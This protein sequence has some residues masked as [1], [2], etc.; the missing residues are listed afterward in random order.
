M[1][2]TI[3]N[4]LRPSA[5]RAR[6]E[7]ARAAE[8]Q[9]AMRA[10]KDQILSSPQ[11]T[12]GFLVEKFRGHLLQDGT[13]LLPRIDLCSPL[14]P[15]GP[16]TWV[17][18]DYAE[19]LKS[20]VQALGVSPS[21]ID[22]ITIGGYR[23]GLTIFAGDRRLFIIGDAFVIGSEPIR[24]DHAECA[25]CAYWICQGLLKRKP[26]LKDELLAPIRRGG[27]TRMVL[28]R[29]GEGDWMTECAWGC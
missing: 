17:Q 1:F 19:L 14:G 8:R 4:N 21:D 24:G 15:R 11:A 5:R 16:K 22:K 28:T 23:E 9:A 12:L 7:Q 10:E 18:L 20:A 3:I 2:T 25:I 13:I 26:S 6:A 29:S 27:T